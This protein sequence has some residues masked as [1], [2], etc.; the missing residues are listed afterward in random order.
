ML[1]SS[2]AEEDTPAAGVAKLD[3]HSCRVTAMFLQVSAQPLLWVGL[4]S[5]HLLIYDT[6]TCVPVMMTRRHV[7]AIR[8]IQFMRVIGEGGREDEEGEE[9]GEEGK[10]EEVEEEEGEEK[11][12]WWISSV[13]PIAHERPV[14]VLLTCG[15]GFSS[16]PDHCSSKN[17][18]MF[19]NSSS[20]L[21]FSF[22][23]TS[24]YYLPSSPSFPF[25]DSL[26][27]HGVLLVWDSSMPR[28]K[29][30]FD[31]MRRTQKPYR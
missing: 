1:S 26:E 10:E 20:R 4:A 27:N 8:S 9:E 2:L 28:I 14:N 16:R 31:E 29:R 3:P 15:L 18:G 11:G 25:Q 17:P 23:R 5:G 12:R 7:N 24:L 30:E 22:S 21:L 19:S 6:A 13:L